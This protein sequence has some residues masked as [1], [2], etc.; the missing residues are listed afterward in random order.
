MS[1]LKDN[2]QGR[3]D[4]A[5]VRV[6]EVLVRGPVEKACNGLPLWDWGLGQVLETVIVQSGVPT[7]P[8]QAMDF[9]R[10]LGIVRDE[11]NFQRSSEGP[12]ENRTA[13]DRQTTENAG[14]FS[15]RGRYV[16][17]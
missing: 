1:I 3:L 2:P 4:I 6:A 7:R 8:I 15:N 10:A 13:T 11:R 16:R 17:P 14:P 5:A 12:A 9:A